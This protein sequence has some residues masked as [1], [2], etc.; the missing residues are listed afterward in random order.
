MEAVSGL[1]IRD[2][3]DYKSALQTVRLRILRAVSSAPLHWCRGFG[4]TNPFTGAQDAID[5][6]YCGL[7]LVQTTQRRSPA[8]VTRDVGRSPSFRFSF[9]CMVPEAGYPPTG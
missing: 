7:E 1:Q 4:V 6:G 5:E 8:C 3:A 9:F 2:T